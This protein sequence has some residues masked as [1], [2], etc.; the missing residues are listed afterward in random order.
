MMG[1]LEGYFVPLYQ[2]HHN[3]LTVDNKVFGGGGE[4]EGE[5]VCVG[6]ER[7]EIV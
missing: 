7:E 1:L 6:R 2:Y 4:R 3:P 5:R